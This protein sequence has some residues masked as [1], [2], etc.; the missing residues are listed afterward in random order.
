MP[1]ALPPGCTGE[2]VLL[3][4]HTTFRIGGPASLVTV[5]E[6]GALAELVAGP[7]RWL[8]RG[9]NLLVGD[10]GVAEPVLRLGAAFAG[11]SVLR[12]LGGR[13]TL[14]VGGAHDLAKLVAFCAAEG[15]AGPEGLAGVP[16]TVGG[17]LR[18]NAGTATCWLLDWVARV[19]VLLP[20]EPEP[21]WLERAAL[22][23][24][25]RSSGL[26]RG[27]AFLGCELELAED[28]PVR[29]KATATRLKQAK[30]AS[31]PLALPSAGCVFRNPAR[32]LP[33]GRL[34]DQLGLKGARVGGA[35]I[36]PVHANFIVN[37][38]RR[39]S[40]ADVAALVALIRRRAW[41]ERGV[42]LEMEVEAWACPDHL[43]RHPREL[44]AA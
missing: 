37:P 5:E 17:A 43:Q 18:M 29:L 1:A 42:V 44:A 32:D 7:H 3:A 15:L 21:R 4:E 8:G 23:A 22:P 10:Q 14:A 9:A 41:D 13:A 33:A 12:R 24:A 36:S 27:T 31:Q 30:A 40:A 6:R 11:C 38:E 28:D 19:E 25:Y 39:A 20:G 16:A 2:Q 35:E 34:I 26:P